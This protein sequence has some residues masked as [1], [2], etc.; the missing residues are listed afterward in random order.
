MTGHLVMS[1]LHA[2]SAIGT[3]TRLINMGL[4]PY[5]VSY[6]LIGAVAQRLAR[7]ICEHCRMAYTLTPEQVNRLKQ[8]YGV[9]PD[10]LALSPGK[11]PG[12]GD[13]PD[14][15][16]I[17]YKGQGCQYCRGT[18]YRGR[19]GIFEIVVFNDEL[20]EAIV[21]GVS[22]AELAELA[23]KHGTRTLA[24]DAL[25]KVKKGLTTLEE[26]SSILLER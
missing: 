8:I 9:N 25:E 11:P 24:I 1:S 4:D 14:L 23:I 17:V 19:T 5:M 13:A 21:R 20:R 7:M 2:N 22:T 15:K 26:I 3:V 6:S 16:I 18:G 12:E 10:A